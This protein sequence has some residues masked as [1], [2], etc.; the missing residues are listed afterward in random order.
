MW[1]ASMAAHTLYSLIQSPSAPTTTTA[2]RGLFSF[3]SFFFLRG[4]ELRSEPLFVGLQ[5]STV[6]QSITVEEAAKDWQLGQHIHTHKWTHR[7]TRGFTNLPV[8]MTAQLSQKLLKPTVVALNG[9]FHCV[10]SKTQLAVLHNNRGVEAELESPSSL[11][12]SIR[13]HTNAPSPAGGGFF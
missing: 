2:S 6:A 12:Q 8:E 4:T 1:P 9:G 10:M 7:R 5:C 13:I 3:F 11:P